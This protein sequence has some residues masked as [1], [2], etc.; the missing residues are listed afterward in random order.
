VMSDTSGE[1][2]D[3]TLCLMVRCMIG[4]NTV[5]VPLDW[6]SSRDGFCLPTW[7]R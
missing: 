4:L 1:D 2:F 7:R 3:P 5:W 6:V